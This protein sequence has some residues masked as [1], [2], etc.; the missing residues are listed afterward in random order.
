MGK[1][2]IKVGITGNSGFI[3]NHLTNYLGLNDLFVIIP[4]DKDFFNSPAKLNDF[5][6]SCDVIIHLAA[7]NRHESAKKLYELNVE[8]TTKLIQSLICQRVSPHLIF[9]SSIQESLHNEYG[10][11]KIFCRKE[12]E[13]WA[14][15]AGALFTGLVIPNVFGP[16]GK[17][18]HNSV[19]ATFCHQLI[20]GQT[21]QIISDVELQLIDVDNLSD[22]ISSIIQNQVDCAEYK[23]HPIEK[24][25]VSQVLSIL[26]HFKEQYFKNGVIPSFKS[27]F[28]LKL[29]NTFFSHINFK[30]FFPKVIV[31]H[32]DYRGFF[33]E[34]VKSYGSGQFSFSK[35]HP[36]ITRGN[37]FHTRKLERFIV[38]EGKAQIN[39]RKIGTNEVISFDVEG[40]APTYVDIPTWHT[41]NI[42]N[43]GTSDLI[44][45]F[46]ISEIFCKDDSDTF[47]HNV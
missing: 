28:E 42:I 46:W 2:K 18:F 33:S 10:D 31:K 36:G 44:T 34:L 9:A 17:P 4:F 5:V 38:I 30:S 25:K 11:A 14:C 39:L 43:T 15:D 22:I 1:S 45:L 20:S 6:K 21:P 13:K 16:F 24:I 29:F 7:V 37:H 8:I 23:I 47:P 35:T 27:K 12:L 41:H 32:E 40:N 19:I 3:G 26:F